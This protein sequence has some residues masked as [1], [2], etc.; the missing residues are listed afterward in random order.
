[1]P[2]LERGEGHIDDHGSL[3]G[4]PA[5]GPLRESPMR[6]AEQITAH[7]SNIE[8]TAPSERDV[9]VLAA[10]AQP[11]DSRGPGVEPDG[12]AGGGVLALALSRPTTSYALTTG[13]LA[14]V[15]D[16]VLATSRHTPVNTG[17]CLSD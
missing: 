15:V 10:V 14:A 12:R 3:F 13:E 1:L 6:I 2:P 11:G 4:H 5:G 16:P 8:H 17:P 7:G 9:F